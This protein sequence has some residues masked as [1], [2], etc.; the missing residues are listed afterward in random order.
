[1]RW[2]WSSWT[3]K[4]RIRKAP[5]TAAASTEPRLRRTGGAAERDA[6]W[7]HR[8]PHGSR[9]SHV[10]AVGTRR[11]PRGS[12]LRVADAAPRWT[13]AQFARAVELSYP[14]APWTP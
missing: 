13:P 2:R 6:T 14:R 4:W 7:L 10:G 8:R 1:M 11:A 3:V 9:A 12:V 5:W